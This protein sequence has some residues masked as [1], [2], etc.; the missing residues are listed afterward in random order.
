[1]LELIRSSYIGRTVD[2]LAHE[3]DEGRGY[4]RKAPG[5]W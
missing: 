2:A 1:M 4:L 3:A 5:S